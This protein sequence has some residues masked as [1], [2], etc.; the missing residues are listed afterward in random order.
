MIKKLFIQIFSY[1]HFLLCISSAFGQSQHKID[2]LKLINQS[3]TEKI[4]IA[5]NYNNIAGYYCDTN[6]DSAFFYAY[7]ALEMAGEN[8]FKEIQAEAFYILSYLQEP[9]R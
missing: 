9:H 8:G 4:K 7:K 6:A 5:D 2:S 1:S 3:E